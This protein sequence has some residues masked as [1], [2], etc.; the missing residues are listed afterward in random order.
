MV[1]FWLLCVRH[2]H[3]GLCERQCWDLVCRVFLTDK[4]LLAA[5]IF[6]RASRDPA[7]GFT[8]F[9]RDLIGLH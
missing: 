1:P 6:R 9:V 8:M 3:H 4:C 5:N 2:D 7:E